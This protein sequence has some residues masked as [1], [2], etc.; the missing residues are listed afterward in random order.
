M[1]KS[2]TLEQIRSH[3]TALTRS[4]G[5]R[6][7]GSA[8]NHAA[9]AY[10]AGV[11][12]DSGYEVE[13]QSFD[14]LDWDSAGAELMVDGRAIVATANPFSP[15]CDV[16]ASVVL[17]GDVLELEQ[18]DFAGKIAVLH[19]QLT[20]SP[21]FPKNYPF[22]RVEEHQRIIERLEMGQ[23]A[24]VIAISPASDTPP[25]VIEDGDFTIPSVT[26]SATEGTLLR[27]TKRPVTVRVQS[28]AR[29]GHGANVIGRMAH[30]AREKLILCAHFDTKPGTPGALDNAAGVAAILA[31]ADRL[32]DGKIHTNL[33]I[34][35]FN[36][37]DHYAAPGEIAYINGCGGEFG[38]IALLVN[39]DGVGLRNSPA[40]VAFFNCEDK[41]AADVR[42]LLVGNSRLEETEPWPEGDHSIFAM[43]GVPCIALTSGGIHA[44]I[45]D[46][47]HTPND[48]LELI[49][50]AQIEA[51]V[52]FLESVLLQIGLP[53][54][55]VALF[56]E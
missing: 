6:P 51:A 55:R 5:G 16:T 4:A 15:A 21:L 20:A 29:P 52:E 40:T 54:M 17:A 31:L 26:V 44:L 10:I 32:A 14:C 19:G 38:R 13:R 33:E 41:W 50:P 18:A 7:V 35:V 47:L 48:T 11:L 8:A 34:V 42:A 30:P 23:T 9:E 1:N 39:I 24:A 46:V 45:A 3:L 36:G 25:P 22:F 53:K 2:R 28:T 12:N 49:E 37:E 27:E 43:Q 56:T